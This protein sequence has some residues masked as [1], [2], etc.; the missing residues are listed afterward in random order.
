MHKLV[1]NQ[2]IPRPLDEVFAF[3]AHPDN[4]A[5]ITPPS[6]RFELA[7]RRTGRCGPD[8]RS[9]IAIRP[10]PVFPVRWRTAHR[11]YDPPRSFVDVQ[12]PR[13]VPSLGASRTLP[14]RSMAGP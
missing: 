3:F 14:S 8:S 1:A 5:R 6:M 10:L 9:T 11:G 12:A 13:A 2:F 7:L 4:L